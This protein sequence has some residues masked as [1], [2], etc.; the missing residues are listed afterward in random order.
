MARIIQAIRTERQVYEGNLEFKVGDV[1]DGGK[2]IEKITRSIGG[3]SD[4]SSAGPATLGPNCPTFVV[5]LVANKQATHIA[6]P[7]RVI[8]SVVF[9]DVKKKKGTEEP[10]I[11]MTKES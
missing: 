3:L 4:I 6:I 2:T 8:D 11:E 1:I 7:E 10:E 5:T 9:I